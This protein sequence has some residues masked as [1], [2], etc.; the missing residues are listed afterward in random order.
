MAEAGN[1]VLSRLWLSLEVAISAFR[2]CE[3]CD[4]RL[5]F[6]GGEPPRKHKPGLLLACCDEVY[7]ARFATTLIETAKRNSPNQHVHIHVYQPSQAWKSKASRV[8]GSNSGLSLS[9]ED[10]RRNPFENGGKDHIYFAAARFA[11]AR[12]IVE[13]S[14]SA[15]LVMDIDG[16][17]VRSLDE[18]FAAFEDHDVGLIRRRTVKPWQKNA[19]GAVLIQPTQN[20]IE[21]IRR[22]ADVLHRVLAQKPEFHVDQMVI[23]SVY[24]SFRLSSKRLRVFPLTQ[25]F[26]DWDF[27][28]DSYIWSAKGDRKLGFADLVQRVTGASPA[29]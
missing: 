12:R 9:W 24:R 1:R 28:P 20:G 2:A 27:L 6:I 21:F 10:S 23:H 16:L 25:A 5:N 13:Q 17:I 18:P 26:A 11:V 4:V 19:A 29:E 14:R 15:V 7:Y 8:V 22:V 3:E